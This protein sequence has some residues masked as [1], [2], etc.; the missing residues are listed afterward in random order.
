[1]VTRTPSGRPGQRKVLLVSD[2]VRRQGQFEATLEVNG[3]RLERA[4]GFEQAGN[5]T[6]L[7]GPEIVLV[8]LHNGGDPA[9]TEQCQNFVRKIRDASDAPPVIVLSASEQAQDTAALLRAGA[10]DFLVE[11]FSPA[12]MLRRIE[13]ALFA[14]AERRRGARFLAPRRPSRAG[15]RRRGRRQSTEQPRRDTRSGRPIDRARRG[16]SAGH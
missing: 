8:D 9:L 4:H 3:F 5:L 7:L 13:V 15:Q 10:T 14:A 16:H 2:D 12:D 6:T 1:M 11:P